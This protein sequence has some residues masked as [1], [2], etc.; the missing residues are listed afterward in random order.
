MYFYNHQLSYPC[1]AS[2]CNF[3]HVLIVALLLQ[4][5]ES[6][7]APVSNHHATGHCQNVAITKHY[8]MEL[9]SSKYS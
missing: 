2:I 7:S 5:G 1:Y 9:I 8:M 3:Y 6:K 4:Y